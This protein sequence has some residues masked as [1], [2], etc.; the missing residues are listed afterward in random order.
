MISYAQAISAIGAL[1]LRGGTRLV[2]LAQALGQVLAQPVALAQDQPPFDRATMDGFA[3]ML[4]AGTATYRIV[5]TVAAGDAW[6]GDLRAGEA[7]RI[8][9]GAPCPAGTTVVPS[10]A[11]RET[12]DLVVCD[13]AALVADRNIAWRGEDGAAG[14]MIV[15]ASTRMTPLTMAVA[16]MCGAEHVLVHAAPRLALVT[17]G[18]EVGGAG[19]GGI[20]DSNG[21]FLESFAAAMG[22]MI[23]REHARDELAAVRAALGGA[24]TQ[25]EVIITTGGVSRSAA[26][27]VPEAA[28]A[29]GYRV[30]FHQVAMQP[31]KPVLL[32]QHD[33][34]RLLVG[35][36]GNAVSVVTTAHLILL[37]VLA[38][39]LGGCQVRW[40]ELPLAVAR[41]VAPKRQQFLPARLTARG[42]EP[43]PWNGSG[44]LIA[45]AAGTGL[46]DLPAGAAIE[47]GA[48][49]RYMPYVGNSAGGTALIPPRGGT[50]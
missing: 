30:V 41:T 33:D 5:A 10:E 31:G 34:G 20:R 25:A 22:C 36:P 18:N 38:R 23:V 40:A 27:L 35:L 6:T 46:V 24:R 47:A 44:D 32:A 3:V 49:V 16:A 28:A 14:A 9:T 7:V 50:R 29:E 43:I 1:P 39:L 19:P 8:M 48:T 11:A 26:D 45:A 42:V 37:P 21:P 12:G 15:P 17:T 2:P 4:A 13:A